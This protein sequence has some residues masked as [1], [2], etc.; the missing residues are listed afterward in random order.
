[1]PIVT[2]FGDSSCEFFWFIKAVIKFTSIYYSFHYCSK[3]CA[4]RVFPNCAYI[5][6]SRVHHVYSCLTAQRHI[7]SYPNIT[8]AGLTKTHSSPSPGRVGSP[9]LLPLLLLPPFLVTPLLLPPL[10]WPPLL[11]LCV[12]LVFVV[13]HLMLPTKFPVPRFSMSLVTNGAYQVTP[14]R[15]DCSVVCSSCSSVCCLYLRVPALLDRP[16]LSLLLDIFD[17]YG[18]FYQGNRIFH[19]WTVSVQLKFPFC[20]HVLARLLPFSH[21]LYFL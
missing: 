17:V 8:C 18:Y 7:V 1:M 10:L 9:L 5:T 2:S 19:A 15:P 3:R 20:F 4:L 6:L 21:E 12:T 14:K 13:P 16:F 11:F